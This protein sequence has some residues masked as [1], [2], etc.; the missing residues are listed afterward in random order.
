[1]VET[2]IKNVNLNDN[3]IL[4][5]LVGLIIGIF[6]FY[7]TESNVSLSL[8]GEKFYNTDTTSNS[9][10][11]EQIDKYI[12][13]IDNSI[14]KYLGGISDNMINVKKRGWDIHRIDKNVNDIFNKL[15]Y[16]RNQNKLYNTNGVLI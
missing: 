15:N 8:G 6:I 4:Y 12:N 2:N 5:L 10:S 13:N 1:M 7:M 9:T 16:S 14:D 11:T 3:V